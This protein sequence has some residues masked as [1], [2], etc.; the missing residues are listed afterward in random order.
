MEY[1]CRLYIGSELKKIFFVTVH[2]S[3]SSSYA[4]NSLTYP[5]SLK[6][7]ARQ[8]KALV[9]VS[10]FTADMIQAIDTPYT[11]CTEDWQDESSTSRSSALPPY[12]LL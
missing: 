10:M 7:E 2:V 12:Q 6:H 11:L 5:S 8:G 9:I 4:L 3:L 1:T